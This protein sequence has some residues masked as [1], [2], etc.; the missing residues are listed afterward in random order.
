M[1]VKDKEINP[2]NQH[3]SVCLHENK[4]GTFDQFFQQMSVRI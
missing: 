3:C 2:S 1:Y 4:I